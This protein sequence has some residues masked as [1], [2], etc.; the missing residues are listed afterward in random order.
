[1]GK[2]KKDIL[3]TRCSFLNFGAGESKFCTCKIKQHAIHQ[4]LKHIYNIILELVTDLLV[5]IH[6]NLI[7]GIE[8]KDCLYCY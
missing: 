4:V 1:M 6:G 3:V 2:K 7:G 8:H 5:W